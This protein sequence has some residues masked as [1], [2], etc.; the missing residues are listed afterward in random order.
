MNRRK[1]SHVIAAGIL[2]ALLV[3]P[4]P[5]LAEALGTHDVSVW[6][7]IAKLWQHELAAALSKGRVF[8]KEGYG[9][10]PNGSKPAGSNLVNPDPSSGSNNESTSGSGL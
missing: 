1:L 7:S 2:A 10:D 9:I 8:R 3:L 6:Q 4:G 5:A